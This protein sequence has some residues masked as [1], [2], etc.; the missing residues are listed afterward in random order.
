MVCLRNIWCGAVGGRAHVTAGR[1]T[2]G[3]LSRAAACAASAAH[4][5][6][7]AGTKVVRRARR[8][9]NTPF[10]LSGYCRWRGFWCDI[11]PYILYCTPIG[12]NHV[13]ARLRGPRFARSRTVPVAY[14]TQNTAGLPTIPYRTRQSHLLWQDYSRQATITHTPLSAVSA[15]RVVPAAP[16]QSLEVER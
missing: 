5:V 11:G 15:L 4:L 13:R 16:G 9:L 10:L 14:F 12:N 8:H 6:A 3:S 1:S 2:E 7:A